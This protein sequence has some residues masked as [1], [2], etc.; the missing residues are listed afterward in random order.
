LTD[1]AAFYDRALRRIDRM[2]FI[3]A[4]AT[5]VFFLVRSG[6][7]DAIACAIAGAASLYNFS[8]LQRV[9]GGIAPDSGRSKAGRA[10]LGGLRFLMLGAICFV[11]I[12][13]FE[14]SLAAVFAGLLIS[15]AAV[16]AE[17]L[18]ELFFTA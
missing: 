1:D 9:A 6:W 5:V 4:A 16:L 8:R 3:L 13:Y 14:A 15:V 17:I 2:A 12:K 18:Y 11:I 10:V 7:K